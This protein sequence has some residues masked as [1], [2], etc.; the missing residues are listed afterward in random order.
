MVDIKMTKNDAIMNRQGKCWY[1]VG[2]LLRGSFRSLLK[3]FRFLYGNLEWEE[4]KG[5]L[6]SIFYI[7]GDVEIL[8]KINNITVEWNE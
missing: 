7:K 1:E 8:E 4:D 6:E 2:A 5:F 3:R